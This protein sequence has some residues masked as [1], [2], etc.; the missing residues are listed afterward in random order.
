[1]GLR[2]LFLL[3]YA[4]ELSLSH[5]FK[6]ALGEFF[7][8]TLFGKQAGKL[9]RHKRRFGIVFIF[10]DIHYKAASLFLGSCFGAASLKLLYAAGSVEDLLVAGVERVAV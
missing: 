4:L 1:M 5:V 10:G 9:G 6:L 8:L 7:Y 2:H 3:G